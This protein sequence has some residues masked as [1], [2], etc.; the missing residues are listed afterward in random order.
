[1]LLNVLSHGDIPMV[2]KSTGLV[3]KEMLQDIKE[4]IQR[5]EP[6]ID[7][8]EGKLFGKQGGKIAQLFKQY[9]T[10]VDE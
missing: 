9:L 5:E 2:E 7:L 10:E 1:M 4:E 3:I 8:T 6:E